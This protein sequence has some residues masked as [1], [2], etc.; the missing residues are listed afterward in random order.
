MDL[1]ISG[2]AESITSVFQVPGIFDSRSSLCDGFN[3]TVKEAGCCTISQ[4]ILNLPSDKPVFVFGYFQNYRYFEKY[5]ND[6]KR[7]LS[8]R[9][10][11]LLAAKNK[12]KMLFTGRF[13]GRTGSDLLDHTLVGV[14]I[15]RGDYL[16]DAIKASGYTVAP[17]EY[18]YRAMNYMRIRYHK[19]LFIVCS[20]DINWSNEI[21]RNKSDVIVA[22][23]GSAA[24]DMALLTLMNHTII[25]VGTYGFW[26]A[27][28]NPQN[29]TVIYYKDFV[30]P[31]SKHSRSFDKPYTDI[32]YPY[33]IGM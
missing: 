9:G 22:P 27:W 14:H 33:W 28:L 7:L 25:T 5:K 1:C 30:R 19:I 29:G 8:F 32:Y 10:H 6:I 4:E 24:V 20:Q 2:S 16:E 12:L 18:L 13:A 3:I 23:V 26:S 17:K 21:F 11:I 15:R 31:N